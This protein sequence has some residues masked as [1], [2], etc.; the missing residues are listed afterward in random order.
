MSE[1]LGAD[2][3]GKAQSLRI[4]FKD[5]KVYGVDSVD[6]LAMCAQIGVYNA[7]LGGWLDVGHFIHFSVKESVAGFQLR[8]RFWLGHIDLPLDNRLRLCNGIVTSIVNTRLARSFA[9]RFI[10]GRKSLFDLGVANYRHAKEEF[11]VLASF[12]ADAYHRASAQSMPPLYSK[13]QR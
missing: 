1:A 3:G 7:G 9:A 10:D 13:S 8:S 12:L 4:Q 2:I 11:A 5:P 6:G